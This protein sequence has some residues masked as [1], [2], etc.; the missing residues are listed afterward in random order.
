MKLYAV[1]VGPGDS[2]DVTVGVVEILK[3]SPVI[4]IPTKKKG[5]ES[6]AYKIVKNYIRES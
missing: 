3:N 1:G 6:A 4:F 5:E 2:K